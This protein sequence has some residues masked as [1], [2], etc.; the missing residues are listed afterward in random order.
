MAAASVKGLSKVEMKLLTDFMNTVLAREYSEG[1]TIQ[2]LNLN[3]DTNNGFTIE[4][5]E[6]VNNVVENP[7]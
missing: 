7:E 4:L 5:Q 1:V 3:Y 2:K 6:T